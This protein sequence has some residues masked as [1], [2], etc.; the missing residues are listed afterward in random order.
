ML[1][2]DELVAL[3]AKVEFSTASADELTSVAIDIGVA[4]Y[5]AVV[6]ANGLGALKTRSLI[7]QHVVFFSLTRSLSGAG[8][9][10]LQHH[11]S[12]SGHCQMR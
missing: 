5:N 3:A 10:V 11:V 4:E 2:V 6:Y 9:P 1:L 7:L 8:G 12:G